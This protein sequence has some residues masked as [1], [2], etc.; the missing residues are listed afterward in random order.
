MNFVRSGRIIDSI[1]IID[2]RAAKSFSRVRKL[3]DRYGIK[4]QPAGGLALNLHGAGRPTFDIDLVVP[5]GQWK[6]SLD[7]LSNVAIDR[8]YLGLEHEPNPAAL[9]MAEGPWVKV[10][11]SGT[12]A[13]E[14][15]KI[16]GAYKKH[17]SNEVEMAASGNPLVN[18]INSKMASGL[19]AIDR[20]K[21]L[22]DVQEII[23]AQNLDRS[24]ATKLH[25]SVRTAFVKLIPFRRPSSVRN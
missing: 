12:T 23:K 3:L 20:Q 22:G 21:D 13:G 1:T 24:F 10:W 17:A 9:K 6:R 16:R 2:P 18:I 11:P 7:I 5:A 14:I 19:S 4:F 8:E 15:A 25:P